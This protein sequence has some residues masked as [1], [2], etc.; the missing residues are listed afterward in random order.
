[1]DPISLWEIRDPRVRI[2]HIQ[3]S[4]SCYSTYQRIK[5]SGLRAFFPIWNGCFVI[6]ILLLV[7]RRDYL[8]KY[9][10]HCG[11][12]LLEEQTAF[13]KAVVM[14]VLLLPFRR[15]VAQY[16]IQHLKVNFIR[17]WWSE[18]IWDIQILFKQFLS[19][20]THTPAGSFQRCC[21][22]CC[23]LF[24]LVKITKRTQISWL[25]WMSFCLLVFWFK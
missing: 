1:M 9:R 20:F 3:S 23:N 12:T 8:I 7:L 13:L 24:F 17:L 18:H 19:H 15:E 4:S 10:S 21:I 5:Q 14:L 6:L 11:G 2:Y 16:G 25:L 22:P